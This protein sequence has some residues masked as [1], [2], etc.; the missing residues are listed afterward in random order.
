MVYRYFS[1]NGVIL[2]IG[3]AVVPVDS[4][5]YAYGFGVYETIRVTNGRVDF[6]AEHSERLLESAR[7]ITLDHTFSV[8]FVEKAV[9]EL[10]KKVQP[11]TCNLKLLLIGGP[12]KESADLYILCLNP[13]FPDRKL[14]RDGAVCITYGYE[15]AYPHA[16]SLNM[17]QS[18]LA[19]RQARGRQAYDALFVNRESCITEGSRTNFFCMRGR[20]VVTPPDDE[21][22][23]GVMRKAALRVASESGFAIEQRPIP[24]NDLSRYDSA[25]VTSTSSKIMPVRSVGDHH[26]GPPSP[27]LKELMDKLDHF[28][29]T[30]EGRMD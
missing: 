3:Q 28:L 18:Y 8:P 11:G 25:F 2:P 20:T 10:V 13:F 9:T 19:Y 22:L 6:L 16:K 14:Y 4:I 24:L 27:E 17:L 26:F 23:L 21:V 29:A 30:C 12:D 15:R 1:H 7:I 5:E